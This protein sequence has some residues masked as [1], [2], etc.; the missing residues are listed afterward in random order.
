METI[1]KK[2]LRWGRR[3]SSALGC[4]RFWDW[5]GRNRTGQGRM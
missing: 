1:D 2:P 5:G 4:V 3:N